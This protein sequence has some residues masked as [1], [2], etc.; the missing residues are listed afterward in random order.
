[1]IFS[2]DAGGLPNTEHKNLGKLLPFAIDSDRPNLPCRYGILAAGPHASACAVLAGGSTVDSSSHLQPN[3]SQA[4]IPVNSGR[5]V[6]SLADSESLRAAEQRCA[7]QPVLGPWT[8]I[9]AGL[10]SSTI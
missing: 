7:R 8:Y 5:A 9:S 4:R 3:K 2:H 1:M 6:P 10:R